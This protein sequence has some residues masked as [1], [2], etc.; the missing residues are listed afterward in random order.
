MAETAALMP[1]AVIQA[2]A[3]V[4]SHSLV[5]AHVLVG[6]CAYVGSRVVLQAGVTV[7]GHLLPEQALPNIVEDDCQ[8]GG[9]SGLYDGVVLGAGSILLPGTVVSAQTGVFD[10]PAGRWYKPD[11]LGN[12]WLPPRLIIG[13]GSRPTGPAALGLHVA[14]PI[15]VGRRE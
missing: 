14:M 15:I 3:H 4:G 9:G 5:D 11:T 12:L 13:M 7:A 10:L 8:L 6:N 1:S 2:G